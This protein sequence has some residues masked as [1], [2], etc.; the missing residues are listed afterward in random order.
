LRNGDILE[1]DDLAL[2][3][4]EL[5]L[6][7]SERHRAAVVALQ[8]AHEP[9]EQDDHDRERE[10]GEQAGE[11]DAVVVLHHELVGNLVLVE[12]PGGLHLVHRAGGVEGIS[13]HQHPAD[14]LTLDRDLLHLLFGDEGPEPGVV[15]D[16]ASLSG[17]LGEDEDRQHHEGDDEPEDVR[18][19]QITHRASGREP[20]F[21]GWIG[22]EDSL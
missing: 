9:Q 19:R 8:V 6:G 3:G 10:E 11:P 16:F 17:G 4:M 20:Y 1:G 15:D 14:L 22:A 2:I 13:S 18:A 12:H 5:C 21:R 7:L